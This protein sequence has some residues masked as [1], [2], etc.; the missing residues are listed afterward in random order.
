MSDK[1]YR[2]E[3]IR[4]WKDKK[5]V[6]D[7]LIAS[8]RDI[9]RYEMEGMG[10]TTEY[11]VMSSMNDTSL[12]FV[13]RA[14]DNNKLIACWG[15]VT[16][17]G[18]EKNT[19]IIWALG[20]NEIERFRKSFVQESDRII[21]RWLDFYGELTNTIAAKNKKAIAWLKRLGAEFSNTRTIKGVEYMDFVLRKKGD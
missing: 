8:L 4:T 18:Q 13:A 15:L 14:N 10:F 16:L 20:T 19:Y 1:G 17:V 11:G 12:V 9:D 2:I 5:K 21:K 3:T 7:E 6:G